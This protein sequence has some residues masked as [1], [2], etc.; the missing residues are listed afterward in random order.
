MSYNY[1]IPTLKD[2]Q[3]YWPGL[4]IASLIAITSLFL[5][6]HYGGPAF[7]FAL[8][9]GMSV[10]FIRDNETFAKGIGFASN[11]ILKIGVALL[12]L[13]IG[14]EELSTL[15]TPS[16]ILVISGIILTILIAFLISKV[17]KLSNQLGLL[18][19]VS[20]AVCGASAALATSSCLPKSKEQERDT[21]FTIVIVY[22]AQYNCNGN[23]S[24][25]YQVF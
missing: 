23:I 2:I 12:G 5:S 19:G 16:I 17:L 22:S 13:R 9:I 1:N 11:T 20:T 7:L 6:E 15:G 4:A 3:A 18:V 14:L 21:I 10:N 24:Y 25:H 8:L